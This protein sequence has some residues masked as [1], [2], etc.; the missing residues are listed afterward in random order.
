M[1]NIQEEKIKGYDHRSPKRRIM[2][3]VVN[4]DDISGSHM[5]HNMPISNRICLIKLDSK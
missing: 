5:I 2:K 3:T 4:I 1:E